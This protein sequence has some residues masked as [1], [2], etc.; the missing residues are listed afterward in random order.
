[1]DN[2]VDKLLKRFEVAKVPALMWRSKLLDAYR[3]IM[4]NRDSFT[5]PSPGQQLDALVYDGTAILAAR[6]L[7]SKLHSTL[8]PPFIKWADLVSGS[9]IAEDEKKA[10]D[11]ALQ[12]ITNI[13]FKYLQA[14]NFDQAVNEGY[15]D[16]TI[17][18]ALLKFD[19]G[20]DDRP[21]NFTAIPIN[22]AAF[23][24]DCNGVLDNVYRE[25]NV[26]LRDI[27]DLWPEAKISSSLLHLLT[28]DENKKVMIKEMSTVKNL[29]FD[30]KEY[31]YTVIE[32]VDNTIIYE[33]KSQSTCW[34][35]FRWSKL[36]GDTFGRGPGIEMLSVIKRLN[37][38]VEYELTGA[39]LSI[40]PPFVSYNNSEWNS[41]T[42]RVRPNELIQLNA[43]GA[44]AAGMRP[45]EP[46]MTNPNVQI[47][48]YIT[49]KL[50]SQIKKAFYSDPL[51]P[52]DSPAKTATEITIRQQNLMEEIGPAFGR[53]QSE[54]LV[55][56]IERGIYILSRKGLIPALKIDGKVI[57]IKYRSP[58]ARSQAQ[59]DVLGFSQFY[60]SLASIVG[61]EM[62][63]IGINPEQLPLWLGERFGIDMK[64][65]KSPFDIQLI[66]QQMQQ[67]AMQKFQQQQEQMKEAA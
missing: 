35:P 51:G 53:L 3:Y 28:Q 56:I 7:A 19:E 43:M 18:T 48:Q 47:A 55:R 41:N 23:E 44:M 20:T 34:I 2:K 49:E 4:P 16:L 13:F 40:A 26:N 5:M 39:A 50:E 29:Y 10:V 33:L 58:L 63:L 64:L 67:V 1:M 17:G 38:V 11:E 14:S 8:T 54:F 65:I 61:P 42:F 15:M 22:Q 24:E 6:Q 37:K 59:A 12:E 52:I 30:T 45:L 31:T 62:A 27:N 60:E 9:E 57:S 25:F 66:Q 21:F 32:T 46:L 36:A